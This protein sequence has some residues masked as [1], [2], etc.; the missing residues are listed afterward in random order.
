MTDSGFATNL[1]VVNGR[2]TNTYRDAMGGDHLGSYDVPTILDDYVREHPDFSFHGD[3][4]IL[5]VTGYNGVLGYRSSIRTYGDTPHTRAQGQQAK[6]VADALKADG[7][8]FASHTWG[9]IDLTTA[10]LSRI[11][12][13]AQRWDR[14]VRPIVGATDEL[15]YPF[16]AD[17]SGMA[18]YTA[19]NEKFAFLNGHEGFE[20][21]FPIDA[22]TAAWS[23][24][25]RNSWRQARINVDGITMQREL[26]GHT[27]PLENFFT[28]ADTIDPQRPMPLPK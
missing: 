22:S 23:Q 13:D 9:H 16:G 6:L 3:K 10:S 21:F 20:Y 12:A 14:E 19:D 26:D 27:T 18:E 17:I 5:A 7:W 28:A 8:Q 25:T 4:G 11:Q 1:T 24:L 15:V 2:V